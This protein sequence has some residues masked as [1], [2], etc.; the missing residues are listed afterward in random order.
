MHAAPSLLVTVRR[1]AV[2]RTFVAVVA[3]AAAGAF[4][5]WTALHAQA[6]DP[7]WIAAAAAAAAAPAAAALVRR[8]PACLRWDGVRWYLGPANAAP[9]DLEPGSLIAAIDAGSF[10]L[11]RFRA[12]SGGKAQWLPVQRSALEGSWTALRRAVYS[13][14]PASGPTDDPLSPA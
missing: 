7:G 9:E 1:F 14:R 4:A 12:Q 13:P 10:L 8:A 5:A 2:W 6:A 3:A 11:L